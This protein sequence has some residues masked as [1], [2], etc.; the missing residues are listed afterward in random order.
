MRQGFYPKLEHELA[1]WKGQG[2]KARFWLRDDD[3]IRVTPAL[4]RLADVAD[5][6]KKRIG[7][8]VIPA[9]LEQSLIDALRNDQ[10]H[11][12]PMCHGLHHANYG[13]VFAPDEFGPARSI[14]ALRR[15]AAEALKIF[16]SAFPSTAP[17]FVP[18]YCMISKT[19]EQELAQI[20]FAGLSNVPS[21][22]AR[23]LSSLNARTGLLPLN[24]L[25]TVSTLVTAGSS[26][27]SVHIDLIDWKRKSA[28]SR[29]NIEAKVLGELR[30]RRKHYISPDT[31]IGILAHHLVHDNQ[32]WLALE[33]LL[34]FLDSHE[35]AEFPALESLIA[36]AMKD[37]G[38]PTSTYHAAKQPV[39]R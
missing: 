12:F 11:F 25:P 9:K 24:L 33:D 20:G 35:A 38:A 3:A 22:V 37:G 31:P 23:K 21:T 36:Q 27:L 4:N 14:D 32:I 6:F 34:A 18:P 8:A 30:M 2:L 39:D 7:L 13:T 19:F 17:Y 28:H 10:H 15:D 29:V 16:M 1:K 26:D 5:K